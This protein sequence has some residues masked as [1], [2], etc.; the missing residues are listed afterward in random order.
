MPTI[1]FP[2]LSRAPST[3]TW[4]L[5]SSTL[6]HLSPLSGSM[7]TLSTPGARWAFSAAWPAISG[8]DRR[9]IEAF[10]AQLNGRAGRF[11]YSPPEYHFPKGTARTATVN[12]AGQTGS[13]INV[14]LVAFATLLAGDFFEVN[15]ELK[16]MTASATADAGGAAT[17]SFGPPLRA[18]PPNGAA[19][20]LTAP[21]ATFMLSDDQAALPVGPGGYAD[22]TLDAIEAFL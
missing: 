17:L 11:Y 15:G 22:F 19:I 12:G 3:L 4:G 21:R 18:A 13:A 20:S 6:T 1:S 8:S 14:S 7:R 9:L 16:R 2:A 5:R 10:I